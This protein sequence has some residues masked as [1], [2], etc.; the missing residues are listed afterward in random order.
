MFALIEAEGSLTHGSVVV[1][2]CL[3]LLANL[4]RLNISNQSYFREIGCVSKLSK[5]LMGVIKEQESEGGVSA[6]A[7]P[8]RDKNLWGLLA[9]LRLFL[10]KGGVGTPA[11][12]A[13]LWHAGVVQQVLHIA[14]SPGTDVT[15]QAEV[16]APNQLFR[17]VG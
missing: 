13:A 1:Q 11:N 10:V 4:L 5:L 6:W 9:I 16:C 2:D 12:Q 15:L 8:Q 17:R 14:F 7:R 3:S